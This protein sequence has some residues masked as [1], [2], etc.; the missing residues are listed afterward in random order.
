MHSSHHVHPLCSK[1]AVALDSHRVPIQV[2]EMVKVTAGP[3]AG[4]SGRIKHIHRAVLFLHSVQRQENAGVFVAR[5][6]HVVQAGTKVRTLDVE[7]AAVWRLFSP[8]G[9]CGCASGAPYCS[10]H[11]RRWRRRRWC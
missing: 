4:S 3:A 2:G 5:A 11:G 1:R 10:Y 6:R 9:A 7:G 8:P